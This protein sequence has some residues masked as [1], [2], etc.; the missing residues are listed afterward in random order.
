VNDVLMPRR[1]R[2]VFLLLTATRWL[3]VGMIIGI[4]SLLAL[5][6]GLTVPQVMTY[7]AA[8]GIAVALLELPTS[9]FA[10]AFGRKPV[11]V[12]A[13]VVNVVAGIAYAMAQGFWTF[14]VA[15]FLMGVYRALDS[16][17]LEAWYV[18]TVHHHEPGAD[19]DRDLAHQGSVVG[20]SIAVT[21]VLS[22][23]LI[24]LDPVPGWHPFTLP[25]LLHV[26]LC[27]VH[28]VASVVLLR[29]PPRAEGAT[30]AWDSVR[31]TPTVIGDGVRLVRRNHVLGALVAVELFWATGMVVFEQFQSLRL[32]EL[33]GS[34]TAAGAWSGPVGAVGW[35]VF[36]VGSA[37]AGV[38]TPR[39]GVA[40]T[41]VLAR[42]L[43][44]CG[45]LVMGLVAGPVALVAAYLV[46]YTLHGVCGA[47]H[48][49]LLHREAT[50]ANR[51]TVLSLNSLA[52]FAAFA[53]ASPALGHLAGATTT[54]TAMIAAGAF[55]V[56]GAFF[57]LPAARKE[58]TSRPHP[59]ASEP[60][61]S[62]GDPAESV[63]V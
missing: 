63:G 39:I 19:V 6:R 61:G 14:A 29:E 40:R 45:A 30:R 57:Y 26:V 52:G 31:A 3:P 48:M 42:V 10:D 18:D 9:G 51:A 7:V 25:L 11:L 44:G 27:A 36:A 28:L 38:L 58:K 2:R 34:E 55:S 32:A 62:T 41:A 24:A 49:A 12:A 21:A 8:Q 20:A 5:E 50:S 15:A 37:I 46:T 33:L 16:G 54:Q 23:A 22:G 53:A 60:A 59:A 43:N 4:F 13:G 47:P 35:G 1:A 56:L 17:P